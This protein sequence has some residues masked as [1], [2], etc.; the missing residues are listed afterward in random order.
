MT[1]H[2]G[3]RSIHLVACSLFIVAGCAS[4]DRISAFLRPMA[5]GGP[6]LPES[7]FERVV[8]EDY[9]NQLPRDSVREFLPLAQTLLHDQRPEARKRALMCFLTVTLRRSLDSTALLEPYV[10]DLLRIAD[11]RADPLR[12]M[13]RYILGNSQPKASPRTIA[14]VVAH[15]ADKDNTP[16]E[17]G[18]MACSVLKDGT[19][20]QVH[21]AITYLHKRGAPEI[22]NAVMRCLRA[23]PPTNNTDILAFMGS[24]LD[25]PD[26]SVR[27]AAIE[28]VARVP[29]VERSPFLAQLGRI[30]NDPNE[31]PELRSAA[32]DALKK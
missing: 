26:S 31:P 9:I 28:L 27:R 32:A 6:I 2:Y 3:L 20:P 13:A 30:S 25:S 4:E 5:N 18:A 29:M 11:D 24:G 17:T 7:E 19:G 14:Y 1:S 12:N 10:P 16:E 21:D 22:T 23:L 15:L 8:N